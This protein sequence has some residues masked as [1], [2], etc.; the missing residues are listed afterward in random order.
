MSLSIEK[1][2]NALL[3][4]P[5]IN[6]PKNDF[7]WTSGWSHQSYKYADKLGTSEA[8]H[9]AN[10]VKTR[11][12]SKATEKA[13]VKEL[14]DRSNDTVSA[15]VLTEGAANALSKLAKQLGLDLT[16]QYGQ[17]PPPHPVG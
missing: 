9:L 2:V 3:N 11:Y 14:F 10:A 12:P 13:I 17:T 6:K 15:L 16:F 5:T 7:Y 4:D 1:K 8:K